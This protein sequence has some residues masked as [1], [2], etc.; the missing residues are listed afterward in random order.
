M[1]VVIEDGYLSKEMNE[2]EV[3]MVLDK[4]Y[5]PELVGP[6]CFLDLLSVLARCSLHIRL[7]TRHV[8]MTR[9]TLIYD[10]N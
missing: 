4:R 3:E 8:V 2:Y 9:S 7:Q 1:V 10:I 5:S 6:A